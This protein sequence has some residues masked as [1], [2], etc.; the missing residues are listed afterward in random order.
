M[1][2]DPAPDYLYDLERIGEAIV[3]LLADYTTAY[4]FQPIYLLQ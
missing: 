2:P 1:R 4:A 3:L